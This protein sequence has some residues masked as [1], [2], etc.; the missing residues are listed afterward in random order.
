[1]SIDLVNCVEDALVAEIGFVLCVQVKSSSI[2]S[3]HLRVRK[4]LH[5]YFYFQS[6][7]PKKIKLTFS[8][9][10]YNFS[11]TFFFQWRTQIWLPFLVKFLTC[12]QRRSYEKL[13]ICGFHEMAKNFVRLQSWVFHCAKECF[14]LY[15]LQYMTFL[16]FTC[17]SNLVGSS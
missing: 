10:Y 13:K 16:N 7:F 5:I 14:A 11:V 4:H 9:T 8:K 3:F 15:C 2:S 17:I 12:F 6:K 1:M